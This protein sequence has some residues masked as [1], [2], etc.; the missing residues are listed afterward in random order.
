VRLVAIGGSDA[1]IAAALRARELNELG[2]GDGIHLLHSMGDTFALIRTLERS[3]IEHAVIVGAGYIGLEMAEAL[4]T[5]GLSV[6]Q[7]EQL[8]EV[9]PTI[10][11]ELG[12]LVHDELE[13]HS[14]EVSCS[15][16]ADRPPRS[17]TR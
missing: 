14:V 10:D 9:L 8:P 12:A 16:R 1:G 17:S 11:P 5:R 4:T 3:Q 13:R 6:T 15:T 7:V 2:P